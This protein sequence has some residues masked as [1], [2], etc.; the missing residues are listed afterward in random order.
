MEC[1]ASSSGSSSCARCETHERTIQALQQQMIHQANSYRRLLQMPLLT[2]MDSAFLP[3]TP[4]TTPVCKSIDTLPSKPTLE[5]MPTEMLDRIASFVPRDSILQ[6]CHAVPYYKYIS[7]AMFDFAHPHKL[8]KQ[9]KPLLFNVW[10]HLCLDDLPFESTLPVPISRLHALETYSNIVSKLG[11]HVVIEDLEGMEAILGALPERID[12][13][14]QYHARQLKGTDKF[15]LALHNANKVIKTLTLGCNYL[16]LHKYEPGLLD[17]TVKWL[18]TLPIHEVRFWNL[19]SVVPTQLLG[20]LRLMPMLSS[21]E[22]RHVEDLAGAGLSECKSLRRL[23]IA[24]LFDGD[25]SPEVLVQQAVDIL[26]A[27]TI[28][29]VEVSLPE[30][31]QNFVCTDLGD[32]VASLFAQQG[33]HVPDPAQYEPVRMRVCRKRE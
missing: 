12:V 20:G 10:P 17:M 5:S 29:Q 13:V 23:S 7:T 15:F 8:R 32:L 18:V 11:G 6:L 30:N 31:W 21:L 2:G 26:E 1:P 27:T 9:G 33:W 16:E 24:D 22:L 14:V 19:M 25:E 3:K 4:A 28:Q